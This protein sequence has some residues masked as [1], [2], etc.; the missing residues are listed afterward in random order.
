[1]AMLVMAVMR[2]ILGPCSDS[3]SYGDVMAVAMGFNEPC[4]NVEVMAVVMM[5]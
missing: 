3:S 2:P 4:S 5:W 1:M